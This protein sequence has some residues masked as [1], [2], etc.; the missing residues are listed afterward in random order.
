[1]VGFCLNENYTAPQK[2]LLIFFYYKNFFIHNSTNK[3]TS[4]FDLLN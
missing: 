4:E 2:T 1:M 3:K